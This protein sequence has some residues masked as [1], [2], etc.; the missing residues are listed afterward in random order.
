M[1]YIAVAIGG[2]AVLG[3]GSSMLSGGAANR[4]GRQSRDWNNERFREQRGA[5]GGLA[6][7]GSYLDMMGDQNLSPEHRA[8]LQQ[9]L[10]SQGLADGGVVGAQRGLARQSTQA[11]QRIMQGYN[12]D[13]QSLS[14]MGQGNLA[15]MQNVYGG[16]GQQASQWGRGRAD[17]I[18][19]DSASN[20]SGMQ[21]Q[22]AARMAAS[23]FGNST[24]AM[25]AQSAN[26]TLANRAMQDQLQGLSEAQIDRQMSVGMA[27]ASS[28]ERMGENQMGRDYARSA[29]WSDLQLQNL[30][31]NLN[32]R[33]APLNTAMQ[34][35]QSQIMNPWLSHPQGPGAGI[36][37]LASAGGALAGGLAA[38]GGYLMAKEGNQQP[39]QNPGPGI[40]G[41]AS[42]YYGPAFR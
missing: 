28:R 22:T 6:F 38:Y 1:S 40:P 3:A 2:S 17:I 33:Q 35:Q 26:S 7:G 29:G 14:A 42:P 39:A 34:V 21:D 10:E 16:L 9:F 4:A 32:M 41:G 19:R 15:A 30:N 23:G 37:P 12:R 20:L 36:S 13:T 5:L 24:A 27:G 8:Q 31:R 25:H 18:R 11:G